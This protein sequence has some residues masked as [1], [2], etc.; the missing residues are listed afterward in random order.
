MSRVRRPRPAPHYAKPSGTCPGTGKLRWATRD[1]ARAHK[2]RL[3][4]KGDT[5]ASALRTFH[6]DPGCGDWHVGHS[7]ISF[8]ERP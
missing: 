6:C 2:R 5:R 3:I 4:A 7:S 1:A 8:G